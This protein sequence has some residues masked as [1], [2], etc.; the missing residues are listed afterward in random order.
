MATAKTKEPPAET[1]VDEPPKDEEQI[2]TKANL[3][4]V[5]AEILPD[6]LKGESTETETE[7]ETE[8]TGKR[9]TAREEEGRT[10]AEVK[11]AIDEFKAAF[12]GEIDKGSD[13]PEAE[14]VPGSKA[15]RWIE[16]VL[17]GAE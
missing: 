12:K 15:V 16:K 1:E 8:D 10:Y 5:L 2:V 14:T 17:W 4:E 13:K 9:P 3:R 6:F 7:T 11:K